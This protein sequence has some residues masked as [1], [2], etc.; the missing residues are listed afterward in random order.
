MTVARSRQRLSTNVAD[1]RLWNV[2]LL[3]EQLSRNARVADDVA[4][5]VCGAPGAVR[6][7]EERKDRNDVFLRKQNEGCLTM[8]F[9]MAAAM[10]LPAEALP[11]PANQVSLGG[12][13]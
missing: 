7:L 13:V 1:S 8:L 4:E 11:M 3:H 5:G 12:T 10:L 6:G 9:A 2:G